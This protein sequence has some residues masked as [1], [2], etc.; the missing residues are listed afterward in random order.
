MRSPAYTAFSMLVALVLALALSLSIQSANASEVAETLLLEYQSSAEEPFSLEAGSALW[1]REVNGRSCT[2]CHS[3]SVEKKGQH[4]RTG[5]VIDPM[6]PSKNASRL[7]DS[8]KIKK[9]FLRNCKWTFGRECTAQEKG[10]ILFWLS[11]Q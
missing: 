7:T 9:W 2:S 10:D 4:K 3:T 5:K 8:N 6:A 11:Q 1:K